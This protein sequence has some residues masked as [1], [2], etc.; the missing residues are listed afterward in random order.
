MSVHGLTP[1]EP[2]SHEAHKG[3]RFAAV[4][5]ASI[6]IAFVYTAWN[7]DIVFRVPGVGTLIRFPC[8]T[9]SFSPSG[10]SVQIQAFENIDAAALA[11]AANE[12]HAVTALVD[13][14]FDRELPEVLCGASLR[15]RVAHVERAFRKGRMPPISELQLSGA[16]NTALTEVGAP[17]WARTSI[18]QIHFLRTNARAYLPRFIGT[19]GSQYKLSHQMAP[20]ESAWV[21]MSVAKLMTLDVQLD[22]RDGPDAWVQRME[23]RMERYRNRAIP[24]GVL[25]IG[26]SP[27]GRD[28][29]QDL[30]R[31]DSET[32]LAA[33]RL[34]DRLGFPK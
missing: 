23:E 34:L 3:S 30:W 2:R 12:R 11:A 17:Q 22:F 9:Y 21:A 5:L 13:A 14:V 19:V 31:K 10:D 4:I 8:S 6:Q 1:V 26:V 32:S 27:V 28:P 15:R 7:P 16:A 18:R 25:V 29:I 33:E 20:V 24:S